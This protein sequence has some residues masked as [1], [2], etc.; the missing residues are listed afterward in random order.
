MRKGVQMSTQPIFKPCGCAPQGLTRAF[1]LWQCAGCGH[2][3]RAPRSARAQCGG[4]GRAKGA[5][6][7]GFGHCGVD[8]LEGAGHCGDMAHAA[9]VPPAHRAECRD[10]LCGGCWA[11]CGHAFEAGQ[12]GRLPHPEVEYLTESD[13][14]GYFRARD[15]FLRCVGC[16]ELAPNG[17]D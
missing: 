10:P 12:A 1:A 13:S 6:P 14:R 11:P 8:W 15:S 16:L 9:S 17:M 3:Q 5:N 2:V 7:R 4:C